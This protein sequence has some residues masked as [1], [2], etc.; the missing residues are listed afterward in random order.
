[1]KWTFIEIF[2]RVLVQLL[3]LLA[4]WHIQ[5]YWLSQDKDGW[6][7]FMAFCW[8]GNLFWF[9]SYKSWISKKDK[10]D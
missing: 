10:K 8:S 2:Q 3:A 1:M 6:T 4:C 9:D 7:F 5:V